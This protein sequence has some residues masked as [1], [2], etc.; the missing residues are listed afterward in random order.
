MR[1]GLYQWCIPAV[2]TGEQTAVRIDQNDESIWVLN[3]HLLV[4]ATCDVQAVLVFYVLVHEV[5]IC[6]LLKKALM[7][8][9]P[10]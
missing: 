1:V 10:G 6:D 3:A 5:L 8:K 2:A 4:E 7:A 9:A